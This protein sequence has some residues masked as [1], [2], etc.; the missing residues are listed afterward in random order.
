MERVYH[1]AAAVK[2]CK[3]PLVGCTTFFVEG[4]AAGNRIRICCALYLCR[5]SLQR[6]REVGVSLGLHLGGETSLLGDYR[7]PTA[8]AW[9]SM[10]I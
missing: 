3:E 10:T 8:V 2:C 7:S 5:A 1:P 6:T 9:V 4:K